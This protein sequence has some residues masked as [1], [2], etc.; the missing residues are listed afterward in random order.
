MLLLAR[1]KREVSDKSEGVGVDSYL[2]RQ[3]LSEDSERQFRS[4]AYA[5]GATIE[6]KWM[7]FFSTLH[8]ERDLIAESRTSPNVK[9]FS[10]VASV[11]VGIVTGANK[12][13]SARSNC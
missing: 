5:N 2:D 10:E 6:G 8:V 12:L 3:V 13:F 9:R 7:P 1:R 11:D 4:A